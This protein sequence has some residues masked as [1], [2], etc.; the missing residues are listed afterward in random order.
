MHAFLIKGPNKNLFF[1]PDHD[2]W[3]STLDFVDKK[4]IIDWFN[5]ENIDIA[6]IDGTFWS[7]DELI[8]REQKIVPHPTVSETLELIGKK[9]KHDPEI[10]FTHLNHTNPLN[11][12][13]SE[14][15]Q[16][17]EYMGWGVAKEGEFFNL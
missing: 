14:E 8:G 3:E 17:V 6:L 4:T 10:K 12:E 2:S 16:K 7:S 9:R 15:Y 13:S 1:L 5:S 11:Y